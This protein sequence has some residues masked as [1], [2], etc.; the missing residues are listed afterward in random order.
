[1]SKYQFETDQLGVS[2]TGFH[3]LRNRFNYE[4]ILFSEADEIRI[5]KG[6]QIKNWA[7]VLII[8]ISLLGLGLFMGIKVVYEFFFADNFHHFYIEQF[9]LPVLPITIGIYSIY[10][11]LKS[12]FVLIIVREGKNKILP[13]EDL[14]KNS[15]TDEL[16]IFLS[17]FITR[18]KFKCNY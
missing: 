15:K 9:A 3:L 8:G 2:E 18:E 6:K 5:E 11:S 12:G 1:M 14:N 16:K 13:L 4:T 17:Q 10:S 7:L